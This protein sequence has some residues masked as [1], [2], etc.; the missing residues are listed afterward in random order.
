MHPQAQ[1]ISTQRASGPAVRSAD[2]LPV[3]Q[4]ECD[5]GKS[6][7]RRGLSLASGREVDITMT[8]GDPGF[9]IQAGAVRLEDDLRNTPF[10]G[11]GA[12]KAAGAIE[13][14]S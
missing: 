1:T 13:P 12:Q 7:Q 2:R 8:R 5:E 14:P 10:S 6:R 11:H 3:N 4:T 9:V